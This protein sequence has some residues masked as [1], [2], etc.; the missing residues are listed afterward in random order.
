MHQAIDGIITSE[1]IVPITMAIST[2]IITILTI[3]NG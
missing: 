2:A 3:W 1:V